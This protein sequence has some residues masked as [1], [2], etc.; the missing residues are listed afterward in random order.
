MPEMKYSPEQIA[1]A[2][3]KERLGGICYFSICGAGETLLPESTIE[4][5]KKLLEN[6]HYVNIT[7]NGTLTKRLGELMDKLDSDERSRMHFAFSLHYIELKRLNMLDRFAQNV[8]MVK[9]AGCSFLVQLNLCDEYIPYIDEIKEYCLE[10][11]GAYPQIAAT[12]KE[13]D[14]TSD[15]ELYTEHT[16]E[17][18]V[19]LGKEF[20]SPL[21]DFTMRNFNSP[22]KEFCFAGDWAFT[23][24]LANGI[25]RRC[26]ASSRGYDIFKNPEKPIS[27]CAIG[28]HCN[29]LFC[30]NS[31]HFM[32]LGVIPEISTPT[33]CELRDRET[34]DNTHW[35]ND[36]TRMFLSS[37]LQESNKEKYNPVKVE[38][39]Y[40][41][42]KTHKKLSAMY[43]R[44][45]RR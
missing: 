30:M 15:V 7:S 5:T 16:F 10:Q 2:L 41:L 29:S 42:D 45:R 35:Y 28:K 18:Y 43:A 23:L 6:G 11:F 40:F 22:R 27:F 31:S 12:R 14:I 17:E 33:Y 36:R 1:K 13:T 37:K 20:E 9:D 38:F 4:I 32:S 19:E 8:K 26:Y 44:I 24:N 34:S 39:Q 25:M 3:T 21:F